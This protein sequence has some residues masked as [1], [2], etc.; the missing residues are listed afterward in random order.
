MFYYCPYTAY[1]Q[2][3]YII[4]KS[5]IIIFPVGYHSIIAKNNLYIWKDKQKMS[6]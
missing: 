5:F 6:Y 3:F 1:C 4:L 2:V